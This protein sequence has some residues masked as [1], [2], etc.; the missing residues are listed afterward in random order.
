MK[1]KKEASKNTLSLFICPENSFGTPNSL[2]CLRDRNLTNVV[3]KE[4]KCPPFRSTTGR[5]PFLTESEN[6]ITI[7]IETERKMPDFHMHKGLGDSEIRTTLALLLG[8]KREPGTGH[9]I[10]PF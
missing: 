2:S 4:G 7:V 6:A 9:F 1:K 8:R 5:T 3:D 10:A